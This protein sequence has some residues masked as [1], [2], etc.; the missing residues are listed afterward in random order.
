[1]NDLVIQLHPCATKDECGL[2]GQRTVYS[3][4]PQLFLARSAEPPASARPR[5][6]TPNVPVSRR[7]EMVC[8]ECGKRHAP[9]LLALVDLARSAERVGR[10]GRHVI[11]PPLTALLDL[12]RAAENY[13]QIPQRPL[14]QPA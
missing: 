8:R 5:A 12:S 7:P 11:C 6:G 9:A 4:G 10:I 14:R 3:A 1:M 2:C 13:A